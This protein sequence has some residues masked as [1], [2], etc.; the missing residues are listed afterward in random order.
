[1]CGDNIARSG[2]ILNACIVFGFQ[3]RKMNRNQANTLTQ[4]THLESRLET[5]PN[6]VPWD[7]MSEK[8]TIL[9]IVTSTWPS[10]AVTV[11]ERTWKRDK[12]TD[13]AK[14]R[15]S[16]RA[17]NKNKVSDKS[18]LANVYYRLN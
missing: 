3:V 11:T 1:M 17:K 15:A 12:D 4:N 10:T 13:R 2:I 6:I 18:F 5:E 14:K 7:T 16:E 9:F 8:Q